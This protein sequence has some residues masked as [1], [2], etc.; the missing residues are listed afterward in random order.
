MVSIQ[1][2]TRQKPGVSTSLFVSISD[3]I[4]GKKYDLSLIFSGSTRSRRLNK[5]NRGKNYIPNILSFPYEKDE[6]EIII[7]L[8]NLKKEAPQYE[9][10]EKKYLIF[11]FIHGC[12]HLKRIDHGTKMENLEDRYLKKYSKGR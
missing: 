1:N 10:S 8:S 7:T 3:E 11:L 9:M 4:L 2:F 12:L 5:E 6:G